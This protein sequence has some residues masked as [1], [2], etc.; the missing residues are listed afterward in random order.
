MLSPLPP[1]TSRIVIRWLCNGKPVSGS[2][3]RCSALSS[4]SGLCTSR[5]L[6]PLGRS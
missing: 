5:R 3:S 4:F 6:P 1:V 2:T